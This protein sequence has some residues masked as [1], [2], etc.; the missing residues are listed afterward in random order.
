[1]PEHSLTPTIR[2]RLE[3]I[4]KANNLMST[5]LP[6]ADMVRCIWHAWS[7]EDAAE[8][9]AECIEAF[10]ALAQDHDLKKAAKFARMLNN[11]S[12]GILTAWKHRISTGPLEGGEHESQA[13][14]AHRLRLQEL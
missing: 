7:Q 5:M 1:M 12:F 2:E 4:R 3:E 9:L 11:H 10:E 8:M 14:Q 13:H 6:L